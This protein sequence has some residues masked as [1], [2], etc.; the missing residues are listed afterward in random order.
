MFP[1]QGP[2]ADFNWVF[3]KASMNIHSQVAENNLPADEKGP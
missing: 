3:E 1:F 2:C